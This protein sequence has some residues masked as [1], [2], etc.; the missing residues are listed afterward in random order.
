MFTR[1]PLIVKSK[2]LSPDE[3]LAPFDAMVNDFLNDRGF[4][5]IS[6]EMVSKGSYP[7]VNIID[8]SDSIQ[9]QAAVPGLTKKDIV[10][11]IDDDV[12]SLSNTQDSKKSFAMGDFLTREIKTSTW[13]RSFFLSENLERSKIKATV[14]NGLLSIDIPKL[15]PTVKKPQS[16]K[17]NIE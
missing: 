13:K 4:K 5:D 8:S 15:K 16:W 2:Y 14:D 11:S 6:R 9:I 3:F 12:L 7:K 10:I 17:V 1:H